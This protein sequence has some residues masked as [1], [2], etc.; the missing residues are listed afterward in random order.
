MHREIQSW[1]S[2]RLNKEMEIVE[3]GHFGPVILLLPTAAA[4][5]LEYE[6]FLMIDTLEKHINAG[7]IKVY[8]INSIN[9]ESWLNNKI[10]GRSKVVR[11]NQ[12][13]EYVYKEVVP[14]IKQRSSLETPIYTC[15]A[16]FG[17]L[18][19][20][21]LFFKNPWAIR[22]CISMSGLYD[23]GK[24]TKGYWDDDC[25]W[26]SPMHYLKDLNVD[27]HLNA[28]KS[29]EHI[30][31]LTGSGDYEAPEGSRY[32]SGLLSHKGIPHNLDVWGYDIHHD[33]PTWRA[34]LP[35]LIET[36]F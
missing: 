18:H 26:N 35:F 20:A 21:N 14:F 34:M 31:F 33:W 7:K 27:D 9:N 30:H 29:S 25:Y 19:A 10:D 8:S 22:G 17:A 36:K 4:D 3:Y 24:Y 11:Q 32:I 13:N 28:I 15:G 12:F 16:S 5:Y 23:L 6:R 2:P 1:Y